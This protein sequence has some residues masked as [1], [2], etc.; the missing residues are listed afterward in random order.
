MAGRRKRSGSRIKSVKAWRLCKGRP[1]TDR[2]PH[3]YVD[4]TTAKGAVVAELE[5]W[6]DW[7]KA[8]DPHYMVEFLDYIAEVRTM[9]AQVLN[10]EIVVDR[11]TDFWYRAQVQPVMP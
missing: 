10:V 7:M 9:D 11:H 1:G 8:Y 2:S 6:A 3:E 5:G 4:A